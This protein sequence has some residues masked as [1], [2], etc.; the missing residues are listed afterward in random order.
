MVTGTRG[1]RTLGVSARRWAEKARHCLLSSSWHPCPLHPVRR[2]KRGAQVASAPHPETQP[3]RAR[4]RLCPSPRRRCCRPEGLPAQRLAEPRTH[5]TPGSNRFLPVRARCHT[6]AGP[7]LWVLGR[8]QRQQTPS[9]G[10][11]PGG[12]RFTANRRG[13]LSAFGHHLPGRGVRA[14]RAPRLC[15]SCRRVRATGRTFFFLTDFY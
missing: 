12:G 5:R 14:G 15:C 1:T 9:P 3:G 6:W 7:A 11:A 10:P 2:C 8:R 13:A 4:T